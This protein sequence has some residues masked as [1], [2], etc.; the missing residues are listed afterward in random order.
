MEEMPHCWRSP[1]GFLGW[2]PCFSCR[3]LDL[4][5]V[6]RH[7]FQLCT[8]MLNLCRCDKQMLIS[9]CRISAT[10]GGASLICRKHQMFCILSP[11]CLNYRLELRSSHDKAFSGIFADLTVSDSLHLLLVTVPRFSIA[12]AFC[13][14]SWKVLPVSLGEKGRQGKFIHLMAEK[15]VK[16]PFMITTG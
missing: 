3:E 11:T 10:L 1:W 16:S 13:N 7:F 5:A 2:L 15:D 9:N 8:W 14:L 12:V 6:C 4:P